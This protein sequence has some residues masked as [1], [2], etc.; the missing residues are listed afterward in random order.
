[1]MSKLMIGRV[2]VLCL[3]LLLA[4]LAHGRKN[5]AERARGEIDQKAAKLRRAHSNIYAHNASDY[6]F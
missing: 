3:C 1:M 6:R 2:F 4:E 5:I